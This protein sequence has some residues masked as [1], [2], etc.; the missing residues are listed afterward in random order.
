MINDIIN[1]IC[2]LLNDRNKL[3]FLSSCKKLNLLK[4]K[5]LYDS[6]VR[7]IKICKLWYFDQFTNV[8]FTSNK[9]LM[10][11]HGFV[12]FPTN[13]KKL[14]VRNYRDNWD[15]P[16]A[17]TNITHLYFV[18]N[19]YFIG[20]NNQEFDINNL[21]FPDKLK[22]ISWTTKLT[23]PIDN[24]PKKLQ[25]IFID[26][27]TVKY[28]EKLQDKKDINIELHTSIDCKNKTVG[29]SCCGR[30]KIVFSSDLKKLVIN[31]KDYIE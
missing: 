24:L 15:L 10:S 12:R 18:G 25:E 4:G 20:D 13:L 2:S 26:N 17:D 31:G 7:L 30:S 28:V 27:E 23:L 16:L 1:L 19:L 8:I 11:L 9:K 3:N 6:K 22:H 14:T 29:C 21:I 5:V